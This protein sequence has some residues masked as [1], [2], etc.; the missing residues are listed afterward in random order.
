MVLL[1]HSFLWITESLLDSAPCTH[2]VPVARTD[3]GGTA[4]DVVALVLVVLAVRVKPDVLE[5]GTATAVV[6]FSWSPNPTNNSVHVVLDA[7]R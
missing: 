3:C 1:P 4:V 2:V 7:S 5:V 6:V